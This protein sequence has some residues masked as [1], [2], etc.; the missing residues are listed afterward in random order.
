MTSLDHMKNIEFSICLACFNGEKYIKDQL[1]SVLAQIGRDDE[2]VISDNGSSDRTLEIIE[3]LHDERIKVLNCTTLGVVKN[4]QNCLLNASGKY[5]VLCDQ[6]DIW[7]DGRLDAA[8]CALYSSDLSVVGMLVVNEH[9]EP[10]ELDSNL[11]P[12]NTSFF[13]TFYSNGFSGCC[14]AFRRNVL[15][16][17]LPFPDQLPM[18]D[19][20]IIL[21]LIMLKMKININKN[22]FILYRRHKNNVSNTANNSKSS[23]VHKI[24]I[25]LL[26]LFFLIL[27][28][29]KIIF[30]RIY[31]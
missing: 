13:K 8:R 2:V 24:Y 23:F 7:L 12:P 1:T 20:W 22:K 15:D 26:I 16:I 30:F 28:Y 18:H 29:F 11:I 9:L 27:R 6:D 19:W 14:L 25:R 21:M 4:F 31:L 17:V 10:L 5:I 3:S